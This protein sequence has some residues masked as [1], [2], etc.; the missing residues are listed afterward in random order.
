MIF[1]KATQTTFNN[2]VCYL[3]V[4]VGTAGLDA[5]SNFRLGIRAVG[6]YLLTT[7]IA[8]VIGLVCV[9]TIQP[10]RLAAKPDESLQNPP[11]E[12]EGSAIDAILDIIR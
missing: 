3:L 8:V 9:L 7:C 10:G 4:Y 6:Y 1:H 12:L 11:P 2:F 5:K